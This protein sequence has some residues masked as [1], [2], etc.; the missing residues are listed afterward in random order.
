MRIVRGGG[1][2]IAAPSLSVARRRSPSP[3]FQLVIPAKAGIQRLRRLSARHR[4]ESRD[5]TTSPRLRSSSRRRP[6]SSAFAA[7]ALVIRAKA[8]IQRLR[9]CFA[10]QLEGRTESPPLRAERRSGTIVLD[11]AEKTLD[12][13]LR[14][15]DGK[16]AQQRERAG[17][18]RRTSRRYR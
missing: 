11:D 10:R 5:A 9:R 12:P 3:L 1:S 15:D 16:R 18:G 2:T 17:G 8:G 14:R 7:S 4:A 13:G 6:G